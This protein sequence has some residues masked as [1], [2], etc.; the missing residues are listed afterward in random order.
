[1]KNIV[2]PESLSLFQWMHGGASNFF[3][4]IGRAYFYC[5]TILIS[6]SQSQIGIQDRLSE[7]IITNQSQIISQPIPPTNIIDSPC[8]PVDPESYHLGPGDVIGIDVFSKVYSRFS[9]KVNPQNG[10]VFPQVG[11]VSVRQQTLATFEKAL[12]TI[13]T[14]RIKCDSVNVYL[15]KGKAVRVSVYG[16]VKN[17]GEITLESYSRLSDALSKIEVLPWG[18]KD[19][20]E[21]TNDGN[22]KTLNLF[23]ILKLGNISDNPLLISGTKIYVPSCLD[24]GKYI[25]FIDGV[26]SSRL[27][28][29]EGAKVRDLAMINE[30]NLNTVRRAISITI[31]RNNQEIVSN[32]YAGDFLQDKD[33]IIVNTS[34]GRV[35]VSGAV[36]K[37]GYFPFDPTIS[38]QQYIAQAGGEEWRGQRTQWKVIRNEIEIPAQSK[39]LLE[40]GDIIIVPG[41]SVLRFNEYLNVLVAI[42]TVIIAAKSIG[43]F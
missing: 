17:P 24:S 23:N 19:Q 29:P 10:V 20:I 7:N 38:L 27:C 41:K 4:R 35:Y 32:N 28:L 12:T 39:F 34:E 15:E 8:F 31:H 33:S 1:M 36:V 22:L 30:K 25:T 2:E 43:T 13:L 40:P 11:F 3:L 16:A 6:V 9:L 18:K 37:P 21:I 14:Q 42:A 26:F 5:L